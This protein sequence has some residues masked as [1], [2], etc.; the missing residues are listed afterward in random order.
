MAA[1]NLER[2]TL[3]SAP[4]GLGVN[5]RRFSTA[6]NV[7]LLLPQ[8]EDL[9]DNR[10]YFERLVSYAQQLYRMQPQSSPGV[11]NMSELRH[12][13]HILQVAPRSDVLVLLTCFSL[14]V[15]F[16][17]VLSVSVGVMLAALLFMRRMAELSEA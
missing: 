10:Q 8:G 6:S 3:E 17:M 2:T 1:L 13:R 15:L 11:W 7:V 9:D 5:R 14:T 4:D 12:F 16:D